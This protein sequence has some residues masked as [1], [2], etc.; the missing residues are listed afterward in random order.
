MGPAPVQLTGLES[1]FSRIVS[2]AIGLGGLVF[3]I[4]FIVGGFSYIT[5]GGDERKVESAKKTL[6]YAIAGLVFMALAY[7][8]LKLISSFTGVTGILNFRIQQ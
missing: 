2:V 3:F 5:A 8:I 6:T 1:I 7:L 4:L